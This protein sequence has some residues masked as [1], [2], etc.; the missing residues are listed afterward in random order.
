MY[1]LLYSYG[2]WLLTKRCSVASPRSVQLKCILCLRA[3][4]RNY[5]YKIIGTAS[6]LDEKEFGVKAVFDN[7][8]KHELRRRIH[9]LKYSIY[10]V[11][12]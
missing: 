1:F 9:M 10:I 12:T 5:D 7:M 8:R 2:V 6:E 11:Y 4:F 3:M